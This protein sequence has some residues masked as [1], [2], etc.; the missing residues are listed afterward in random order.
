MFE[1]VLVIDELKYVAQHG[2]NCDLS[3]DVINV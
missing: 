2:L 1:L 3:C